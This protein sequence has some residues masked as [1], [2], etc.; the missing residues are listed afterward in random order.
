[1]IGSSL[2]STRA[3]KMDES[4]TK[5]KNIRNCQKPKNSAKTRCLE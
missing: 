2:D 3:N 5:S 4:S 1:M